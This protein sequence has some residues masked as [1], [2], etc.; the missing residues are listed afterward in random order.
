MVARVG[1]HYDAAKHVASSNPG[2]IHHV[3]SSQLRHGVRRVVPRVAPGGAGFKRHHHHPTP[4]RLVARSTPDPLALLSSTTAPAW[5][6]VDVALRP[7]TFTPT[8]SVLAPQSSESGAM[9]IVGGAGLLVG[10][11]V[12][13]KAG[14]VIMVGGGVLGLIGLWTYLR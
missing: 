13:G 10:A 9:M 14:T 6:N 1:G 12:G 8:R 4:R 11:I 7:M 2:G 5:T 3:T